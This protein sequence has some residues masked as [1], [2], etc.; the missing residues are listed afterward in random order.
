MSSNGKDLRKELG[1]DRSTIDLLVGGPPCQ[2]FSVGGKQIAKD[3][4]NEGVLAFAQLVTELRPRYFVMENVQGFLSVQHECRRRE[5]CRILEK[6]GYL[7]RL[8]I[9]ALNA[10]NYGVPQRRVRAFAI[11]HLG[12]EEP[13]N[14]PNSLVARKPTVRDAIGDLTLVDRH[15]RDFDADEYDGPFGPVSGFAAPLRRNLS[16]KLGPV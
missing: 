5:F 4:R 14:C 9:R 13:P 6:G 12:G 1:L 8:P 10:Y 16:G 7:V 15:L 3:P 2:G 11:G